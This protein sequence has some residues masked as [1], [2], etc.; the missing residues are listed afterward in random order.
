MVKP[1]DQAVR[2]FWQGRPLSA[3]QNLC[4]RSFVDHRQ[5]VELF[6]YDPSLAVPEG[7]LRRDANEI[8]P[9]DRVMQY[10]VGFGT[11]SPALH[12]NLFRYAMLQRLGGWWV[13]ADVVLLR[14]ELPHGPI[15]FAREDT[16][17][18]AT[19]TLKFPPAHDLLADC[20]RECVKVAETARW[21]QTGSQLFEPLVKKYGLE[22]LAQ[23]YETTYPIPWRQ[24]AVLFDPARA[25][26]VGARCGQANFLHLYNEIWRQSQI[27]LDRRPPEGSFLDVLLARHGIDVGSDRRMDFDDIA[28]QLAW[29]ANW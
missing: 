29:T 18:I 26:E 27:P 17:H 9:T 14:T 2:T 23:A 22:S 21:G 25:E 12:S 16:G 7:V 20:V 28:R 8:W 24:I 3:Y 13:D 15:Y 19:G 4:L 6:S 5:A 1:P 10:Q 11:G